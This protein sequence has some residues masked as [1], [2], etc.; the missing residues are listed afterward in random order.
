MISICAKVLSQLLFY[1]Q[2]ARFSCKTLKVRGLQAAV[3]TFKFIVVIFFFFF[4]FSSQTQ[5]HPSV[6]KTSEFK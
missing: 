5:T 6:S 3:K 1:C 4:V 2:G